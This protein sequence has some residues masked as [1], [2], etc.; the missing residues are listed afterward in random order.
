[1]VGPEMEL[2]TMMSPQKVLS[3][4]SEKIAYKTL[5][6]RPS[7]GGSSD[8]FIT[9][10]LLPFHALSAGPQVPLTHYPSLFNSTS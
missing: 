6:R 5:T 10:P 8:I 9:T 1:M 7:L 2:K 4:E 3:I